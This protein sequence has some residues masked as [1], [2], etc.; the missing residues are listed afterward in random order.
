L[1]LHCQLKRTLQRLLIIASTTK[2]AYHHG[3]TSCTCY[4]DAPAL[5]GFAIP[6]PH[7]L[8]QQRV[9]RHVIAC[10]TSAAASQRG[11]PLSDTTVPSLLPAD[12]IKHGTLARTKIQAA[13]AGLWVVSIGFG[14]FRALQAVTRWGKKTRKRVGGV[15]VDVWEGTAESTG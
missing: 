12:A 15:Q 14:R 3:R 6:S 11:A 8:C 10:Y 13:R 5:Q 4:G 9:N 1:L 7:H 2:R